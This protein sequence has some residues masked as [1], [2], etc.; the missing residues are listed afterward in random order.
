VLS[1]GDNWHNVHHCNPSLARMGVD[2]GQLDSTARLIWA[3]ERIGAVSD[4]H[5]PV[6]ATLDAR[7]RQTV[8]DLRL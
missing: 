1:M 3:L 8:P 7:R 6:R 4:V 5:W 2:R